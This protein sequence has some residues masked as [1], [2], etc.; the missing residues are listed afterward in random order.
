[1]ATFAPC[2]AAMRAALTPPEPPPMTTKSYSFI[3]EKGLILNA[4][5]NKMVLDIDQQNPHWIII[6]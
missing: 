1:M 6:L 3:S 2:P 5:Q 4:I